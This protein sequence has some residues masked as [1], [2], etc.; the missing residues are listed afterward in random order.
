VT[1]EQMVLALAA[2][3]ED[4]PRAGIRIIDVPAIRAARP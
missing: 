4:P 3:V 2:A 1:I